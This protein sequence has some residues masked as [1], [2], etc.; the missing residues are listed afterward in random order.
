[1]S[2]YRDFVKIQMQQLDKSIPA[3]EKMK[4]IGKL[5]QA[6]KSDEPVKKTSDEPV[7]K[8]VK[9]L[10]KKPVKKDIVGGAYVKK[11]KT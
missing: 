3:P 6:S 4:L 9:R 7:K 1:M 10:V 2:N 8:L 5:W 11:I